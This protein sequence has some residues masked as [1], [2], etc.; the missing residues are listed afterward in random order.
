[1][2]RFLG[3]KYTGKVRIEE[4]SRSVTLGS[5][6]AKNTKKACKIMASL[7][8]KG[9]RQYLPA[10]NV[11]ESIL[12]DFN[13]IRHTPFMICNAARIE[14]GDPDYRMFSKDSSTPAV[15]RIMDRLDEEVA[16]LAH[17]AELKHWVPL[18]KIPSARAPRA[19]DTYDHVHLWFLEVCEGPWSIKSRYLVED[20]RYGLIFFSSLGDMLSVPTPISD[21]I[22]TIGSVLVEENFWKTGRTVE[23]LG[24]DPSWNPKQLSK[25]LEEGE[26]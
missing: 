16:D 23:Q 25:F 13:S 17:A 4:A 2:G 11:L 26:I 5:F 10:K 3:D 24:I 15:C 21:S 14:M 6:P 9:T 20:I 22:I 12:F 7:Y 19:R 1:M 8:P 18:Y